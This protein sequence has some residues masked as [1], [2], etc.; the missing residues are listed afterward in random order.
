[1]SVIRN[2][3]KKNKLINDLYIKY[4]WREKRISYG[5]EN[6]DKTFYV[7]RRARGNSGLLS[8]VM[9]NL[10]QIK[11][12]VDNGYIPVID[13]QNEGNTY[14]SEEQIGQTNAWE[15]FFEQ[16]CGFGLSDIDKSKNVVLSYG[17]IDD[18]L[19]FPGDRTLL[20]TYELDAWKNICKEYIIVKADLKKAFEKKRNEIFDGKRVL[21]VLARGTDYVVNK[22]HGHTVQPTVEQ[23]LPQINEVIDKYKC[24]SIYLATEDED[25]YDRL[26]RE[27][28]ERLIAPDVARYSLK[29][30][31]N[32]NEMI[33]KD[34]DSMYI[35]GREYLESIWMLSMCNCLVAGNVS[36]S[37]GASLM[38]EGYEYSYIFDLGIYP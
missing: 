15:M 4:K 19:G 10:G 17:L 33:I 16:P 9:T 29:N 21:G 2:I 22:P 8:Y 26:E 32:I 18:R 1:M 5:E 3:A 20:N 24:D 36:G 6:P 34:S 25:I 28:K 7:I 23:L 35:K 13:M 30:G 37:L 11:Y 14:L 31:E 38:S 12:A 27:Y